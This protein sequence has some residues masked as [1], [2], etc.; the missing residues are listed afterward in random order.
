MRA[1]VNGMT[2]VTR[3]V[4]TATRPRFLSRSSAAAAR[5]PMSVDKA[6]DPSRRASTKAAAAPRSDP[7][8]A[9]PTPQPKP[10]TTPAVVERTLRGTGPSVQAAYAIAN[11]T[12]PIGPVSPKDRRASR[13]GQ[14]AMRTTT[15]AAATIAIR[16]MSLHHVFRSLEEAAADVRAPSS[17]SSAAVSVM[18]VGGRGRPRQAS[19]WWAR[20][21]WGS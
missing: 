17:G 7:A 10:K 13:T 12:G 8:Y 4:R 9:T 2:G 6:S 19:T 18:A 5:C 16:P 21:A 20:V 11:R 14:P 3:S 15:V 1:A